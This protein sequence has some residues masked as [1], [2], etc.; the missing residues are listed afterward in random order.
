MKPQPASDRTAAVS[1]PR[2]IRY[3]SFDGL[4]IPALI[5]QPPPKFRGPRPVLID[6]HGGP[7]AQSRPRM[8][9]LWNYLSCELGI[10]VIQPNVRGSSGY[11][12]TYSELDNGRR[13]EDAVQD[14][15]ALL[16]WIGQQPDLDSSRVGIAGGSYGGYLTLAALIRYGDHLRAGI[17]VA[18][19]ADFVT[20]LQGT[21]TTDLE[22]FRVEFGDERDPG[23][24]RFLRRSP[25]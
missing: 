7:Q 23:T 8:A 20:F 11:G 1:D 12:W 14:I 22:A 18:G 15:G 5:R 2:L 9:F 25:P 17:D 13:R 4:L 6:V 16:S 19:V 3:S 21:R 24:N 10:A